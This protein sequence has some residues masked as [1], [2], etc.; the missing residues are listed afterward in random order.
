MHVAENKENVIRE[1]QSNTS[2]V[3]VFTDGSGMEERIGGHSAIPTRTTEDS[4]MIQTGRHY[5]IHMVQGP[6]IITPTGA[7]R[8]TS[9]A[10]TVDEENRNRRGKEKEDHN[11]TILLS[12]T[13]GTPQQRINRE[14]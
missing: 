2:D 9:W 5:T 10:L 11:C 14:K 3:K 1:L 4:P 7:L 6:L 8:T 12:L 13:Y